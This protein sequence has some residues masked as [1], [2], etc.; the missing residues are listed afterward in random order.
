MGPPEQPDYINA[1][2]ALETELAPR[3]L[4][5]ALQSIEAR[6]GRT[7]GP[8]RWGPRTLDLDLLLYGEERIES[9]DLVLPHPGVA[10]RPFVL[11]PLHE[12]VPALEI[13]GRGSLRALLE[14]CSDAGLERLVDGCDGGDRGQGPLDAT[15]DP[16][17]A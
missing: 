16:P 13:P 15:L 11:Y 14:R 17:D 12:L 7:R 8:L 6:H 1:V 2:A 10:E 4:L 9:A 3:A 5:S